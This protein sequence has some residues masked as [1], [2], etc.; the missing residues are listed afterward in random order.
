MEITG[1]Q[2]IFILI[3]LVEWIFTESN[4]VFRGLAEGWTMPVGLASAKL[5][6]VFG[7]LYAFYIG[8]HLIY[9]KKPDGAGTA[10]LRSRG[11]QWALFFYVPYLLYSFAGNMLFL[12]RE[13]GRIE[14]AVFFLAKLLAFIWL[15]A[16][17]I[18][19]FMPGIVL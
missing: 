11:V 6:A 12:F 3:A 4:V 18:S 10:V 16:I 2:I 14:G 15:F 8:R 9:R 1:L 17:W 13:N 7:I 5:V 19:R